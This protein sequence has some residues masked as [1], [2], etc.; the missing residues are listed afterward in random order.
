[1]LVVHP[2]RASQARPAVAAAW[3]CPASIVAQ[4][5]IEL[6][7]PVEEH[8][9]LGPTLGEPLVQVVVGVIRPPVTVTWPL[10]YSVPPWSC[11]GPSMVAIAQFSITTGS[12]L[13]SFP[14][15]WSRRTG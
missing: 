1:V 4:T 6:G 11:R 13:I 2:D 8:R 14:G 7:Q 10:R 3:T 5:G 9:L 12:P 15:K